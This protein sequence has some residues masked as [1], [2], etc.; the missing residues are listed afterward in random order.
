MTEVSCNTE[1]CIRD[2]DCSEYGDV[3]GGCAFCKLNGP[4]SP[5]EIKI[6][7]LAGNPEKE[8]ATSPSEDRAACYRL[9]NRH[10]D[11]AEFGI[12][13]SGCDFCQ[14]NGPKSPEAIKM[15]EL[16]VKQEDQEE[17]STPVKA[18][19]TLLCKRDDDC[20]R[21]QLI[22][23]GCDFC[24]PG[25]PPSPASLEIKNLAD[26]HGQTEDVITADGT[27][28][29]SSL[30]RQEIVQI[31]NAEAQARI[32]LAIRKLNARET[33]TSMST[34]FGSTA[35]EDVD[36]RAEIQRMLNSVSSLLTNVEYRFPGIKCGPGEFAYVQ[37]NPVL[38][39]NDQNQYIV[40]LCNL[41]FE[42][43]EGEQ[44]ETLTHEASHHS[45]S[46]TDDVCVDEL[47]SEHV[48]AHYVDISRDVFLKR[49][50]RESLA[51][52]GKEIYVGQTEVVW[53][54]S[55]K[56]GIGRIRKLTDDVVTLEIIDG[57]NC[58]HRAYGRTVCAKLAKV[59]PLKARV[60]ADN[61][62]YYVQDVDKD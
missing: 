57:K 14:P 43:Y 52:R 2:S 30:S 22:C 44:V 27:V 45:V 49:R 29:T 3:C 19:E 56:S 61:F 25:G 35:Y 24:Q 47:Y 12:L 55:T 23:G 4:P 31:R 8:G 1:L 10:S 42:T 40:H 58:Q 15:E 62:C 34:W 21:Y 33:K 50:D 16:S 17:V 41:F 39:K 26:Q 28:K 9:C 48:K 46:Y 20:T 13:C 51:P 7:Q 32:S 59:D 6:A 60:N 38:A 53:L 5:E 18:C 36:A 37:P 11:C 54:T